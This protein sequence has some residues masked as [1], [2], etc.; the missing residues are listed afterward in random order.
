MPPETSLPL[1]FGIMC[2][3]RGL[4]QFALSCIEKLSDLAV[5]ALLI[6]DNADERRSSPKEKF[7]KAISLN[8]NLWHLQNLLFSVRD[9]PMYR[10]K[11]LDACLPN[12]ARMSCAITR[13]GK[14]SEYFSAEDIARI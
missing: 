11:A 13:K 6:L 4:S 10:T 2:H 8:G 7:K 12:V 3:A 9:I 14:W 5:P 1:R